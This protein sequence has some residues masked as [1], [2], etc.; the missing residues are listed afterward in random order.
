MRV[1]DQ[2]RSRL[3]RPCHKVK[4]PRRQACFFKHF[5]EGRAHGRGILAGFPD[6]G[7]ARDEGLQGL[8]SWKEERVIRGREDQDS[9]DRLPVDLGTHPREPEWLAEGTEPMR[10]QEAGGTALQADPF[11][12]VVAMSS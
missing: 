11:T 1:V 6:D 3:A 2:R 5:D 7:I 12:L 10:A 9:A 4:D 8:D